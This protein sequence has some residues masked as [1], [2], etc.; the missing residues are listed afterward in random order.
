MSETDRQT[1]R[2]TNICIYRAPMELK[3][4][5][6][7][8]YK[9]YNCLLCLQDKIMFVR[10][11]FKTNISEYLLYDLGHKVGIYWR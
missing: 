7:L 3:I 10:D 6:D 4:S 1:D 2:Q 8:L 11:E 9:P 5:I